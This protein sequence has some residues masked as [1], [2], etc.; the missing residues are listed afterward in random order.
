MVNRIILVEF[1]VVDRFHCG[2]QIPYINGFLKIRGI[3]TIYLRSGLVAKGAL[4][5]KNRVRIDDESRN[6]ILKYITENKAECIVFSHQPQEFFINGIKK[7]NKHV[8]WIETFDDSEPNISEFYQRFGID[9]RTLMENIPYFGFININRL[10]R[11]FR[12][13]PHLILFNEC[14]YRKP[15][16][17][18]IFYKDINLPDCVKKNGCTFCINPENSRRERFDEDKIREHILSAIDTTPWDGFRKRLRIVGEIIVHNID[19]FFDIIL[20]NSIDDTDFLFNFRV[21]NFIKNKDKIEKV[22]KLLLGTK[23]RFYLALVGIENFSNIELER[24]NKGFKNYDIF[25][26]LSIIF[27]LKHKY[28][29][30]FDYSEYGGFSL[31]L[32]NPFTRIEDLRLNYHLIKYLG[33]ENLCG[34]LFTSRIRLY[35]EL[36]IYHLAKKAGLITDKYVDFR[37]D[38]ARINFYRAEE[39]WKYKFWSTAQFN[40]YILANN[41]IDKVIQ[42]L[43]NI[44][45]SGN[46]KNLPRNN[47]VKQATE[48]IYYRIEYE[49]MTSYEQRRIGKIEIRDESELKDYLKNIK[50]YFRYY[51]ITE[52]RS[53]VNGIKK[54]LFYSNSLNLDAI[55]EDCLIERANDKKYYNEIGKL[56]GY[57]KC[58]TRHYS[59]NSFYLVNNYLFLLI[60]L[61]Y[62]ENVISDYLNPFSGHFFFIPCSLKCNNAIAFVKKRNEITRKITGYDALRFRKLP[63][64]YLLP[65]DTKKSEFRDNLGYV[66]VHPLKEVGEEF[67]YKVVGASGTDKRLNYILQSDRLVM[68]D[69]FMELYKGKKHIHTFCAEANVWYYK[70]ALDYKFWREFSEAYYKSVIY[71]NRFSQNNNIHMGDFSGIFVKLNRNKDVFFGNGYKL[72][73]NRVERN[74]AVLILGKGNKSIELRIQKAEDAKNYFIKGKKY[75]ISIGGNIDDPSLVKEATELIMKIIDR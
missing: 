53:N 26:F 64:I 29:N 15:I 2:I 4:D 46:P 55:E 65:F 13:L 5:S 52:N 31:I 36:P 7:Y 54:N 37:Y 59:E 11:E 56:L 30:H 22:L 28:S 34:K 50:K 19:R 21:D 24:Y 47:I 9:V 17:T 57:P 14:N 49:F 8:Y 58:C 32:F 72:K 20:K 66:I 1:V 45:E 43:N 51:R 63:V 60:Y 62:R 69:G 27:E 68:R 18:N 3:D 16:K 12:P 23:N 71:G 39:P 40:D 44:S 73:E 67:S 61:R 48:D 75:A 41:N 25:R 10:A 74:V 70:K 42:Y 38:T 6:A 33:I 35:K